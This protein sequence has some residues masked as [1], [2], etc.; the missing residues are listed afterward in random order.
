[1]TLRKVFRNGG[2]QLRQCLF[3]KTLECLDIKSRLSRVFHVR[4]ECIVGTYMVPMN[5]DNCSSTIVI[6]ESAFPP[7]AFKEVAIDTL[8]EDR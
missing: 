7:L 6:K 8:L 5:S 4:S 1:M 2:V 3:P